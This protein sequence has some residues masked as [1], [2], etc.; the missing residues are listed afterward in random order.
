MG[1]TS[2]A[3]SVSANYQQQY[4]YYFS[5]ETRHVAYPHPLNG[6]W[7]ELSSKMVQMRLFLLSKYTSAAN[8][9]SW[10]S[11]H[12]WKWEWVPHSKW[13]TKIDN[14]A[15]SCLYWPKNPEAYQL[16]RPS[17]GLGVGSDNTDEMVIL[18]ISVQRLIFEIWQ[19]A[20]FLCLYQLALAHVNKLTW[21]QLSRVA[22]KTLN[23][24]EI[25]HGTFYKTVGNYIKSNQNL[26]IVLSP[27]QD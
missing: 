21:H 24:L 17:A 18:T 3:C 9:K 16:F 26:I 20:M 4:F 13:Q 14:L 25:L 2:L 5:K 12:Q 1:Q 11:R 6:A 10:W 27:F 15:A 22:W 23:S 8:D 19:Q 7:K